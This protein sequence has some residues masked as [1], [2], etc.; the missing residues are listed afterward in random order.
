MNID[1]LIK[2]WHKIP[3]RAECSFVLRKKINWPFDYAKEEKFCSPV[4]R[5]W[6]LDSRVTLKSTPISS[7]HRSLKTW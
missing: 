5:E 1:K 3:L 2:T 6:A 7:D 4:F